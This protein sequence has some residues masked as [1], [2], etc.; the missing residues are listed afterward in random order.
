MSLRF[1]QVFVGLLALSFV[2]A[3][4]LPSRY[5]NPV[6]SIQG[7]FYP[8]ARP[9]RAIGLALNRR[10]ERPPKDDRVVADVR[11][12]NEQLQRLVSQLTAQLEVLQRLHA[13]RQLIGDAQKLCTPAKVVGNGSAA[14]RESLS[15]RAG[16]FDGVREGMAVLYK[17]GLVGRIDHAGAAGSQVQ[18]CTDRDFGVAAQFRR[19]AKRPDGSVVYETPGQTQPYLK[20][21][22]RGRMVIANVQLKE[23]TSE[24]DN[25]VRV[26]D[27]VVLDD[28]EWEAARG[29][30]MGRIEKIEPARLFAVITV[31]PVANLSALDEVMV[32]NKTAA[33]AQTA[34]EKNANVN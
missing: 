18:L 29:Q 33:E 6:R 10:F 3:F 4:I 7:L 22:G 26:G 20:G 23:T 21:A 12:Q 28:P 8:V 17:H 32:M 1:N 24:I 5:T 9:A 31:A 19:Y 13:D 11:A 15:L 27:I 34:A 16:T 25:P 30:W 2:S 14:Q